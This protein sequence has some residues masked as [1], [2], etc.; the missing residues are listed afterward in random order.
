MTALLRA[1]Y[2]EALKLRR[3]LTAWSAVLAPIAL[4][5]FVFVLYLRSGEAGLGG[6]DAWTSYASNTLALWALCLLP[7][8]IALQTALLAG[9]EHGE[10]GWTH[11][12]ALG[13]PRWSIPA[14]K[15]IIALALLVVATVVLVAAT[16]LGGRLLSV[17]R[18]ELG[19]GTV[20]PIGDVAR[21]ALRMLLAGL[22]IL[23]L[24]SW[25]SMR[26]RGSALPLTVGLTGTLLAWFTVGTGWLRLLP[27]ALPLRALQPEH[28]A[29]AAVMIGGI[30]G[31]V[32]ALLAIGDIARREL[33]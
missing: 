30:G 27:W 28:T 22:A 6:R 32:L 9:V 16:L 21:P 24:Q 25:I 26:R 12:Y 5:A 20:G 10:D 14:A 4:V 31:G 11:L 8:L 18:P 17:L 15:L 7:L 33:R 23:A 13:V 2:A 29:V 3:T 19:F 1:T